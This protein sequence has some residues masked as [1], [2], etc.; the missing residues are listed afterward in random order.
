MTGG[1][2]GGGGGGG[3]V[4][5]GGAGGGGGATGDAGV[6]GGAGGGGA[7]DAGTGGGGGSAVPDPDLAG[8]F[9]ILEFDATTTVA[10]TGD[11]VALHVA[12][13]TAGGPYPVAV[14]AHG[15]QLPPSQYYGYV[16]RLASFGYVA[17]TVD[18]PT[19]ILGNDNPRQARDLL[20]G[21]DWAA[22]AAQLA[23]KVAAMQVL[24]T[25]HS[26]GGKLALL[27]AT[28]DARVKA[29]F[30]IDPV[31]NG[32]AS[33]CNPPS[34]VVVKSLMPSLTIPTGFIGET[35]D[36][37]GQFQA[38]APAADNYT[39]FY[40]R[41]NP[42]SLEVTAVGANHMSFLD[43]VATC[44]LTCSFCNAATAPNAQVNAMAR[45]FLVAFAERHVRGLSA[46]DAYLTG[47]AAQARYVTTGRATVR[48]K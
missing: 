35:L 43:N 15:F 27:A 23:G 29:V 26:L 9:A 41:A 21:V 39:T 12:A 18:F 36:A 11:T 5:G 2:A 6:G 13:P 47:S 33:T 45:A 1:G 17:M 37:T 48:A 31:D 25:G 3:G 40:S 42:P 34:C 28:Y 44:G 46:Y 20:G 7:S 24:M 22:G 19:N 14:F 32:G 10:A 8:P 16:R 30:A 38:C 4:T